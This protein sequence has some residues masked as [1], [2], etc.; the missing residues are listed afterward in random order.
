MQGNPQDFNSKYE[1]IREI[2]TTQHAV[3]YLV[4]SKENG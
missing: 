3:I 4:R 1:Q 2:R